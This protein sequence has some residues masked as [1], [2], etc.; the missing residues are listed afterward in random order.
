MSKKVT[1]VLGELKKLFPHAKIVLTYNNHWELLVAVILSAQCTD[2]IVNRVTEKLFHKYKTLDDYVSAD[3]KEFEQ[4][5]HSTGFYH[6]KA[7]HILASA[8]IIKDRFHGKVPNTMDELLT[9]KGVARKTA[10]VVLGN[11]FGIVEGIA[12][13]THVRRLTKLWGLTKHD[14]PVKIEKDLMRLLPKKEWFDFTYRTIE[15]G[16]AYCIAKKHDHKLC[17]MTRLLHGSVS[18]LR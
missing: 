14:D 11:A 7:K 6:N 13:D 2:K 10:N 3:L 1:I 8:N 5:I 15:Y 4:D 16:R 9:L 18:M 17:P 12:V